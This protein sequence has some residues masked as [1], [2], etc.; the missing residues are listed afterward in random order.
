VILVL[1]ALGA[2]VAVGLALGGTF[3]NLADVHFRLAW[4]AFA[5]LILQWVPAPRDWTHAVGLS[6]GLL[7]ASYVFLLVFVVANFRRPGMAI[8]AVGLLLNGIVIAANG[9][10]P[11]TASAVRSASGSSSFAAEARK[12]ATE[13]GAKHRLAAPDDTLLWLSDRFGV[14]PP[15]GGVFSIGDFFWLVGGAWVVAGLMLRPT[16]REASGSPP[17]RDRAIALPESETLRGPPAGFR[18]PDGRPEPG[19]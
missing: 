2:G 13:G 8:V 9:G 5:G 12:L 14:G 11:V 15:I 19:G 7:I 10:M 18:P 17:A 3:R 6:V 16:P 1:A 4:V